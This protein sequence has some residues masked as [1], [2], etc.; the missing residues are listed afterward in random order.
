M[1]MVDQSYLLEYFV[2]FK[3][4]NFDMYL[5]RSKADKERLNREGSKVYLNLKVLHGDLSFRRTKLLN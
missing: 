5:W 4:I 3:N 1:R 2:V